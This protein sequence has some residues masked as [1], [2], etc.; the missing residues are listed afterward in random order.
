MNAP[1][2]FKQSDLTR[3]CKGVEAAGIRVGRIEIDANGKIVIIAESEAAKPSGG[4][5]DDFR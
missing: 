4:S 2:R 1:A 5:W 3:A